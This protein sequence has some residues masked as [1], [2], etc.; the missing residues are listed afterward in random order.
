M[1]LVNIIARA[2]MGDRSDCELHTFLNPYSYMIARKHLG[3][4]SG[5]DALHVDGIALL[6]LLRMVGVNVRER[7][8]F[9][10]TSMAKEVFA[11]CAGS[12]ATLYLVGARG[13]DIAKCKQIY[14]EL[15][16]NLTIVGASSGY[17]LTATERDQCINKIVDIS[18]DVLVVGMGAPL[19][20]FFLAD[21]REAGWCGEGYTCGGFF[22]Q[23]AK[24]GANYYPAWLDRLNLRWLYRLWDEPKLLKRY[25]LWYPIFMV[26]FFCD[27]IVARRAGSY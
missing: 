20:E 6:V 16:P 23:S 27:V 2:Q 25:L 1:N 21:V 15:Y 17:F 8:S 18:P 12:G 7:E 26:F 13:K 11:K 9:D 5:F 4:F 3:L 14:T 10:M 22:H 24:G 19:Q